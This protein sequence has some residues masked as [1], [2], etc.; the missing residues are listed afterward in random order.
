MTREEWLEVVKTVVAIVYGVLGVLS[1][2]GPLAQ[3]RE[4]FVL[5]SSIVAVF[6]AALGIQLT[7]PTEQI[8]D[9]KARK[10]S[11]K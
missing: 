1:V 7:K 10:A 3:Y 9:I 6:A 11:G 4:W 2:F 5:L 8:A